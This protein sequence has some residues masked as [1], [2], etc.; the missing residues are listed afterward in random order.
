MWDLSFYPVRLIDSRGTLSGQP[1]GTSYLYGIDE[2]LKIFGE[3]KLI[4]TEVA[5]KLSESCQL[6]SSLWCVISWLVISSEW[7]SFRTQ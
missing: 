3:I 5:K 6:V 2:S 1:L 7:S 4:L